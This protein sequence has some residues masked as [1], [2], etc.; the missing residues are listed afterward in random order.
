[1]CVYSLAIVEST[2]CEVPIYFNCFPDF[3]VSFDDSN[4]LKALTLTSSLKALK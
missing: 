3:L 4:I 1:V 2:L